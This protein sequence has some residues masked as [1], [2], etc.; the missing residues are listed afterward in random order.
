MKRRRTKEQG[1]KL[2]GLRRRKIF[3]WAITLSRKRDKLIVRTENFTTTHSKPALTER[4]RLRHHLAQGKSQGL[5]PAR[6][7]SASQPS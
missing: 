4:G 1:P 3:G 6:L 5:G 7:A 2:G